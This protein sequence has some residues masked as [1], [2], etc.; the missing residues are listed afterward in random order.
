MKEGDLPSGI[1]S[2]QPRLIV[3]GKIQSQTV[4]CRAI[5]AQNDHAIRLDSCVPRHSPRGPAS[6]FAAVF[7][8]DS[9]GGRDIGSH[10]GPFSKPADSQ[11][12]RARLRLATTDRLGACGNAHTSGRVGQP[13]GA[14]QYW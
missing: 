5:V 4:L 12:P 11:R 10:R 13:R 14:D 8:V 9:V 6:W 3:G 1:L 7:L 2:S